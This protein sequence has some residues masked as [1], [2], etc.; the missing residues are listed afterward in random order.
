MMPA[1]EISGLAWQLFLHMVKIVD[2]DVL[3]MSHA[4]STRE[5]H[6]MKHSTVLASIVLAASLA[7]CS[8]SAPDI[9]SDFDHS[10]NFASFKTFGY[11][12]PLGTDVDGYPPVVTQSLKSATRHELEARG[13]RHVDSDPDLLVN[14][15]ARL[16]EMGGNDMAQRQHVGYYGYRH[17]AVYQAW[18]SY[19]YRDSDKYTEG[20]INIDLVDAKRK[21]LVWEGVAVGR[22]KDKK[23]T[24]PGPAIDNVVGEIFEKYSYRAGP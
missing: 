15:S 17:I 3:K 23:L 6:S 5:G 7:S 22:V 19:A 1:M 4:L 8:R 16:A 21:Q 12:S 20:T 10:A 24:N 11:A 2:G 9:Q 13:Y 14:F 18:P